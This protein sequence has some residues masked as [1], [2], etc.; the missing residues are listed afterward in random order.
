MCSILQI[1]H[2]ILCLALCVLQALVV[3]INT[4]D[5]SRTDAEDEEVDSG[6]GNVL[7]ADDEAPAGPDGACAH[8]GKVLGQGEG[9]GGAGEVGGAGEDHTPFHYWGP[10]MHSL[11]A[12][13][14]VPELL[15]SSGLGASSRVDSSAGICALEERSEGAEDAGAGA[16]RH[17]CCVFCPSHSVVGKGRVGALSGEG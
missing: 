15:K 10:E 4:T 7:G 5:L 2:L 6:K 16:E 13:G 8:E 3:E 11:W 17:D 9:F 1:L 12:D 14:T